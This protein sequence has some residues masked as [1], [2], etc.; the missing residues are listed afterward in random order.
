VKLSFLSKNFVIVCVVLVGCFSFVQAA[1]KTFVY[2]SEASP[3]SFNPQIASDGTS[4]NA[5]S[6]TIYDQLL[7]FKAGSTDIIPGLAESYSISKD[8]LK[9]TFKLRKG[10]QFHS[11][12]LFK[13]TRDF[14][15]DDVLFS[16]NRQWKAD[17]PYHKIGGGTYEYFESMEMGR[18]I[19]SIN[20]VD[21]YT[22]EFVLNKP[23]S[24]F[25]ANMAMDFASIF[26]AE[27]A[28][29]MM[30]V[31]TPDKLDQ[32]PIGTGPFVFGS[33]V[34]DNIIRYTANNKYFRGKPKLDKLIF[35]ITP[36]ASVR[37]QKLKAGE[38]HLIAEP[39]PSDIQSLL[40]QKDHKFIVLEEEGLNVGYLAM[41]VE[42][43]PLNNLLVR[44]AIGLALNR[45]S[46]LDAIYLGRATL[47]KNPIPP[48]MW[49][50]NTNTKDF[51][52]NIEKA[53][54][55]IAKSG[56]K[57]IS[58]ELWTLPVSRPY[59][60][61][62]KKMGELMQADLA[63]ID[64][65]VKLVT[66]DWPTYLSKTKAGEHQLVQ[67]GWSGDNGDPDNFLNVLLSCGSIAAGSNM[68]RWCNKDFDKAVEQAREAT[69]K[70]V[71][72]SLYMKSQEIVL[73]NQHCIP[74]SHATVFRAMSDKVVNYKI[75][76]FGSELF[77]E[78][79]LK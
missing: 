21:N 70:K 69:D 24:P 59:N 75:H 77:A 43:P 2:C 61:N 41:N 54:Q 23:E 36:D 5:S 38:C 28:E 66:Y 35:A 20:K 53:K 1:E 57:N 56:L 58:L 52:Y 12:S 26:S 67:M 50:Y 65:H 11:N 76:P 29:A 7:T 62:G 74:I 33:Y 47:A 18:I 3:S 78:V 71:R 17:H 46:Y 49:S 30:K 64:I 15:A 27:Y 19:K 8:N 10:V 63:K 51:E 45:A 34:K 14:N 42:K 44:Q 13:P 79:D 73:E 4:F 9:V 22:V 60:P 6:H 31:G 37:Y 72:T 32:Q 25:L 39:N 55:L 16:F 68:A 40:L 48:T